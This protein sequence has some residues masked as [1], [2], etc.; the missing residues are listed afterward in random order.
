VRRFIVGL[1]CGVLL[2]TT[3]AAVAAIPDSG[4]VIH[5]CYKKAG[6]ALR[7]IDSE[8]RLVGGRWVVQKCLSDEAPLNW[9][10]D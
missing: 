4:G 10:Q 1:I 5:G 3:S 6:G 9:R 8:R 7:V 2:A